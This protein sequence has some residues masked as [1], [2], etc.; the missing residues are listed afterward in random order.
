[1]A[2]E[3]NEQLAVNMIQDYKQQ[4]VDKEMKAVAGDG[5]H[6]ATGQMEMPSTNVIT[7]STCTG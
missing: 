7:V 6:S 3:Q 5:Q 2:P 4:D 1:M